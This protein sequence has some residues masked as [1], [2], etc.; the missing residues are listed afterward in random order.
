[1][2]IK[3]SKCPAYSLKFDNIRLTDSPLDDYQR[4]F[5]IALYQK[6]YSQ[7]SIKTPETSIEELNLKQLNIS[8]NEYVVNSFVTSENFTISNLNDLSNSTTDVNNNNSNIA[9]KNIIKSN[10]SPQHNEVNC[11]V[12]DNKIKINKNTKTVKLNCCEYHLPNLRINTRFRDNNEIRLKNEQEQICPLD[13]SLDLSKAS[14]KKIPVSIKN[15]LQLNKDSLKRQ[16]MDCSLSFNQSDEFSN[17]HSHS[18]SEPNDYIMWDHNTGYVNMT[19]ILNIYEDIMKGLISCKRIEANEQQNGKLQRYCRQMYHA[20]MPNNVRKFDDLEARCILREDGCISPGIS[21]SSVQ[22]DKSNNNNKSNNL[23]ASPLGKIDN[24]NDISQEPR[25]SR[26]SVKVEQDSYTSNLNYRQFFIPQHSPRLNNI[27]FKKF[28]I[29]LVKNHNIPPWRIVFANMSY[30]ILVQNIIKGPKETQGIWIPI[31]VARRICSGFCYPIRYFLVPLFGNDF[32][33]LCQE[34]MTMFLITCN[35]FT[36]KK[37]SKTPKDKPNCKKKPSNSQKTQTNSQVMKSIVVSSCSPPPLVR[38]GKVLSDSTIPRKRQNIPNNQSIPKSFKKNCRDKKLKGPISPE[39]KFTEAKVKND[40]TNVLIK[41][42]T[43]QKD[44]MKNEMVRTI[45]TADSKNDHHP[46][47]LPSIHNL[48]ENLS[49]THGEIQNP[50]TVNTKVKLG[51]EQEDHLVSHTHP[52]PISKQLLSMHYEHPR[53]KKPQPSTEQS[54][55]CS[56]PFTSDCSSISSF[57]SSNLSPLQYLDVTYSLRPEN[58]LNYCDNNRNSFGSDTQVLRS[59]QTH[60]SSIPVSNNK[61]SDSKTFLNNK[62]SA[63]DIDI[64]H[65]QLNHN[66]LFSTHPPQIQNRGHT[67]SAQ[68]QSDS[69]MESYTHPQ[70]E[71]HLSLPTLTQPCPQL[72]HISN[73]VSQQLLLPKKNSNYVL[74]QRTSNQ[75]G[76][77]AT[78]LHDQVLEHQVVLQQTFEQQ[79]RNLQMTQSYNNELLLDA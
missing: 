57:S 43:P 64:P 75:V 39:S 6:F 12:L 74:D 70:Q 50:T 72:S 62:G 33:T 16:L 69:I 71:Q 28:V 45:Q 49:G 37:M 18:S 44:N 17:N 2:G 19:T 4:T 24:T 77:H 9:I 3:D 36:I 29:N 5:F 21:S 52:R 79:N 54:K 73:P 30:P 51:S 15:K 46:V 40:D 26:I 63:S 13:G 61:S 66:L 1:M 34:R 56:S 67:S 25:Q 27:S 8:T 32:V 35:S 41:H 76:I 7:N 22:M 23:L 10:E 14:L 68:N 47:K 55:I 31:G 38:G 42:E 20:I 65:R 48:I 58:S 11:E 53:C 59:R 78:A 60:T